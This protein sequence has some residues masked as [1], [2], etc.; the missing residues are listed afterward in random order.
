MVEYMC[1][2]FYLTVN[3]D[4]GKFPTEWRLS[5]VYSTP[6]FIIN[7]MPVPPISVF[8]QAENPC[9]EFKRYIKYWTAI[10]IKVYAD[11]SFGEVRSVFMRIFKSYLEKGVFHWSSK[12]FSGDRYGTE[13][14]RICGLGGQ[15]MVGG[16]RSMVDDELARLDLAA[17][18]LGVAG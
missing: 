7:G 14:R 2:K 8:F 15:D 9:A 6:D 4:A 3:M 11:M 1:E 10:G 13:A 17:A 5:V 18:L 12:R 16:I